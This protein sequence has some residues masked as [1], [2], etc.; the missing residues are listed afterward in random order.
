MRRA[1]GNTI[2]LGETQGRGTP[3]QLTPDIRSTHMYV[4]GSTGTG[5]SKLLERLIRQDIAKWHKSR[6]GLLLLDPH[7]SLYDG[8]MNWLAWNQKW[9]SD[10]PIV[11]IDLRRTDWTV[12]YNVLRTRSKADPAV[13]VENF[14]Q[15]MAHVWGEEGTERTPRF[16][17][18]AS[19]VLW[20]LYEKKQTLIEAEY[21]IALMAKQQRSALTGELSKRSIAQDWAFANSLTPKDFDIQISSTVNRL[22]NF[23]RTEKLRLMFGQSNASLD[24]GKALEEG[25]II[26]VNLSS[27]GAQ[28]SEGDASLF[29]TLLLSD[30]WTAARERGK[31]ID[32]HDVKPFYVYLDEFQNFITP[33]IAK[34]LDQARGFGLHLTLANQF[35]RQIL[36][37]G[38]NG[39]E[40]FDSVMANARSKIVFETRGE[41]NLRPL[42]MDLFMG[43]MNPDEIKH[44]LYSTKVM[45]YVEETRT[46]RGQSSSW[47]D[48]TGEFSGLTSSA[49]LGGRIVDGAD[50][51][52]DM[53]NESDADSE[54]A[55]HMHMKGGGSSETEVPFLNPVMG[56]ELS[57]VQFRPLEEQ[58]FRAMAVLHDQ[59]QRQGV[60]RLKGSP[61]PQTFV[62]PTVDRTPAN[63]EMVDSYLNSAYAKLPFALPSVNADREIKEREAQFLRTLHRGSGEPK[64][65]RRIIAKAPG[66]ARVNDPAV[67]IRTNK[68]SDTTR[69]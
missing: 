44:K 29:A 15:A 33:T 61:R 39:P 8:L 51:D 66:T 3:I 28:V 9:Y 62:T 12:G 36:H 56:K 1:P 58:L 23:L 46:V 52:P 57:S 18:W 37:A 67:E 43:L 41:E 59:K 10:I 17:R 53:Y 63:R 7:G 31:G 32:G 48:A 11:P 49:S 65:A 68:P 20:T 13:L 24:L 16:A 50:E 30:L 26:L 27:E 38:A 25:A 14:V 21:L 40:V 19:N 2:T 4:C 47:S 45:D 60:V 6:C 42:A 22:H 5:K 34:N 69:G 64:G 54:G 55:S 35:P